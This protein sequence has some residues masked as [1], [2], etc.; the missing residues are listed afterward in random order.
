MA[1]Y[2]NFSRY[3]YFEEFYRPNTVNIGWIDLSKPFAKKKPP[4]SLVRRLLDYA[5]V[6]VALARGAHFCELCGSSSYAEG[7]G[8]EEVRLFLGK[9]EM[10]VFS[11]AGIIYAAPNLIYHYVAD[12]HYAPP[13]EFVEAIFACPA[14]P[15]HAYFDKLKELD[16]E[17]WD[18]RALTHKNAQ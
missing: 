15:D 17:W 4:L 6:S 16:L 12:H 18:T 3:S 8:D 14:P 11:Q 1:E 13:E 7:F 10:R 2:P 5:K 9:A